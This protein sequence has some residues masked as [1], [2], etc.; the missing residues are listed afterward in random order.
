MRILEVISSEG[1]ITP[2]QKQVRICLE[3]GDLEGA[4]QAL[5]VDEL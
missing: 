1:Y 2:R 3:E 4:K 5:S